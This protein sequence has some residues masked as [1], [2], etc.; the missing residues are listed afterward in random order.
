MM[1]DVGSPLGPASDYVKPDKITKIN[2]TAT[3]IANIP[4]ENLKIGDKLF[5][6]KHYDWGS[7]HKYVFKGRYPDTMIG[8]DCIEFEEI[9]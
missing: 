7:F 9:V 6:L 2:R 8:S 5:I 4:A 1:I 3:L